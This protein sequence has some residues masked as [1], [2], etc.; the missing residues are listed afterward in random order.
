MNVLPTIKSLIAAAAGGTALVIFAVVVALAVLVMFVIPGG[1]G[2]LTIEWERAKGWLR[3][4]RAFL[5]G[6]NPPLKQPSL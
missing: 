6:K 1:G 5:L 2:I 3:R 4:V